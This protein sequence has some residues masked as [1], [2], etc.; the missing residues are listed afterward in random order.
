M[1][2]LGAVE[3]LNL[4]DMKQV[5]VVVKDLEKAIENYRSKFGIEDFRILEPDFAN[6]TYRGKPTKFRMR[7][8]MAWVGPVQL[9]LIQPLDED[10][11]Y[12]EQLK[13]K[14]EGLNHIGFYVEDIEES[15]QQAKKLGIGIIQSGRSPKGGH[16]YLDTESTCG[17]II[18]IVKPGL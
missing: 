16:A 12:Y 15:E 13:T 10:N 17:A 5:A 7:L 14:G 3:K 1:K 4:G 18:E 9:E 8:A 6:Q 2:D 11:I